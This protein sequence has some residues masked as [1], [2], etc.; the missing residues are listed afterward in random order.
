MSMG[1]AAVQREGG[2]NLIRSDGRRFFLD[3]RD[4]GSAVL[5]AGQRD[6]PPQTVILDLTVSVQDKL[7]VAKQWALAY[8]DRPPEP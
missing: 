7:E 3:Y 5:Y 6:K 8:P 4:N 2:F 1:I